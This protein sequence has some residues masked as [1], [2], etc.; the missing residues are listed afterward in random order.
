MV[1]QDGPL[2]R[3]IGLVR[4]CKLLGTIEDEEYRFT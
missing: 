2:F 4:A 1:T 3:L